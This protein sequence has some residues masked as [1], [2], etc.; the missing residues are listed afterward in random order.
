MQDQDKTLNGSWK[1]TQD[2]L[3]PKQ[4][5]EV[6]DPIRQKP[7]HLPCNMR[8]TVRGEIKDM[9]DSGVIEQTDSP[10]TN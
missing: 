10:R 8:E 7:Y 3:T 6:A 2:M 9:V 1:K 5:K 4:T